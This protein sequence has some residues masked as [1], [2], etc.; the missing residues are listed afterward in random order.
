MAAEYFVEDG[1][2]FFVTFAPLLYFFSDPVL[3]L[4]CAHAVSL[5]CAASVFSRRDEKI[6][7]FSS[8]F[9][10]FCVSATIVADVAL[11][12]RGTCQ[13]E[14]FDAC[15]VFFEAANV[16]CS[17][18]PLLG[19]LLI[20]LALFNLLKCAVRGHALFERSE[21]KRTPS[22]GSLLV[23]KATAA[24]ILVARTE[25][26]R[27]HDKI[28]AILVAYA[29]FL[30]FVAMLEDN[31]PFARRDGK[32]AVF[33][34]L[35]CVNLCHQA[36]AYAVDE[37][38]EALYFISIA[39][40]ATSAFIVLT[41]A[42]DQTKKKGLKLGDAFAFFYTAAAAAAMLYSAIECVGE[43]SPWSSTLFFFFACAVVAKHH[44]CF[45]RDKRDKKIV[46]VFVVVF[47]VLEVVAIV[48]LVMLTAGV[49]GKIGDLR[50]IFVAATVVV[51]ALIT[52]FVQMSRNF[53]LRFNS[54]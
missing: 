5:P 34:F 52:S 13:F 38:L 33:F 32:F 24:T 44:L 27:V 3:Y 18:N 41:N 20:P 10:F 29:I 12:F 15:C 25:T 4:G 9:G 31:G 35:D 8:L 54:K 50:K 2:L 37:M 36:Y 53:D 1:L 45:F 28:A 47:L 51:S 7:F 40:F 39:S 16:S 48:A 19:T 11:L 23:L 14:T 42:V 30:L 46:R 26:E 6:S 43:I 21:Y 22:L 17:R 49:F